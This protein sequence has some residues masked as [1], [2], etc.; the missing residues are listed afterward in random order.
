MALKDDLHMSIGRYEYL[1][2]KY[3][4]VDPDII[5]T[6][7]DADEYV[8]LNDDPSLHIVYIPIPKPPPLD[9]I[10]G[11]G[12]PACEQKFTY[13]IFPKKLQKL[14]ESC[15][16]IDQIWQVLENN[17]RE[18]HNEITWIRKQW[19]L[20]DTGYWFF[21][22][23][24]PTH[25]VWW[26]YVY[27]NFWK[28]K[29]GG[30]PEYRDKNRKFYTGMYY[31]YTTTESPVYDANKKPVY[32]DAEK[33]IIKMRDTG[34]RTILGIAHPKERKEGASNMCLCAEYLEVATHFGVVGG[35]ISSSG[36]HA[37]TKMFDDIMVA[38]WSGMPFFFKPRTTSNQK[39]D[40]EI[41]FNANRQSANK[42]K[43]DEL[44]SSI[45]YS[46]TTEA[47]LYDGGNNIWIN[48]DEAGK[49]DM[50]VYNRHEI[51]KPCVSTGSGA[52]IFGFLTYPS[53]VGDMTGIGAPKFF[54]I[55]QDSHFEKRDISG[56]TLSGM[57]VIYF[58]AYE[59]L[60]GFIDAFG[61]S[62]IETPTPEQAEFIGKNYGSKE[63]LL[64]QRAQLEKDGDVDKLNEKI[65]QFPIKY[66]ECFRTEDGEVG[67]NTKI[68]NEQI[69]EITIN[70]K[71][72]G[73]LGNF[74]R[75][76]DKLDGKVYWEDDPNGRWFLSE[77]LD[78][79]QTNRYIIRTIDINGEKQEHR[80]PIDPKHTSCADTFS[81][82]KKSTVKFSYGG[83]AVFRDYDERIDAGKNVRDWE[84][85]N[86]VCTYLYRPPKQSEYLEDMLMQDEYFGSMQFPE[87]N[88]KDIWRYYEERGRAG[89]LRYEVDIRTGLKKATPG[90][91]SLG[92]SKQRLFNKTRDFIE[93][94]GHKVNHLKLL[95]QWK[96]IEYIE[97]MTKYD[98]LTAAGGCLL[99]T[100]QLMHL[101]RPEEKQK[102]SPKTLLYPVKYA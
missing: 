97:E 91:D 42:L 30:S 53:T 96:N 90:F 76:H 99:G 80:L 61:N 32:L 59:G 20:R 8:V 85:H 78:P 41:K 81:F 15:S 34:F 54:S 6:Y 11:W 28:F 48:V 77:Y 47:K 40:S 56:Q 24:K 93:S 38:G 69:D 43:G 79:D 92:D 46:T 84:T 100:P 4:D 87:N 50:D 3:P 22:N 44:N 71:N 60:A 74:R 1:V 16:T 70:E 51:L 55:C 18:Y 95:M 9:E 12:L 89:Y 57:M 14:V 21:C 62:V 5:K 17:Q 101:M 27:L 19:D 49:A 63:F 52:N 94:H 88:I 26:H 86:F 75:E 31:A 98:L 33:R 25:I 29:T 36:D 13:Q 66:K 45:S 102:E 73:R 82:G 37:K 83:G 7:K 2:R 72:V 10:D 23:G 67:F 39:P 68:L 35:I 58:P 65:R 64:N